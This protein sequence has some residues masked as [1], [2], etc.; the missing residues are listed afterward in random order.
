[1]NINFEELVLGIVKPL[2][3]NPDD[4]LVKTLDA[5]DNLITIQVLCNKEDLGRI[6]GKNGKIATAIRTIAYSGASREGKRVKID[7]E[8][9]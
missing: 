7:I 1:M 8:T 3:N 5:E 4:V 9:F 6:I 2:V